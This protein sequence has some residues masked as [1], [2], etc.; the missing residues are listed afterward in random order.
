MQTASRRSNEASLS[1]DQVLD[2]VKRIV[3]EQMGIPPEQIREQDR[4]DTDL[5]CDSLDVVDIHMEVEE[6]F[7]ITV[8]DE[9][10]VQTITV[11]QI[12]D[13]VLQLLDPS[14]SPRGNAAGGEHS[15][16]QSR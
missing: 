6:H 8:P 5:S 12:V 15:E 1:R 13:G 3:G 9:A 2:A 7:D 16:S 11:A 10:D 14:R 4:L